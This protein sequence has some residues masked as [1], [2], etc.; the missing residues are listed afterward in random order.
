MN[1]VGKATTK[2]KMYRAKKQAASDSTGIDELC[3]IA[4]LMFTSKFL[5]GAHK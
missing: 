2:R 3:S 1:T 5:N 4:A